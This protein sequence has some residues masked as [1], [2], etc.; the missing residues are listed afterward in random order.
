MR[1]FF[2]FFLLRHCYVHVRCR[3]VSFKR[4][5]LQICL[6]LTQ[7]CHQISATN[8]K[9]SGFSWVVISLW[10][11]D[12]RHISVKGD[13]YQYLELWNA[14]RWYTAWTGTQRDRRGAEGGSIE[15]RGIRIRKK[16]TVT[17][18]LSGYYSTALSRKQ[19]YFM[20][21]YARPGPGE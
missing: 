8:A 9:N 12:Q 17:S 19:R 3:H 1:F 2:L 14:V 7:L 5:K 21:C 16:Q 10:P 18:I 20:F 6:P 11:S 4:T 15:C 13:N